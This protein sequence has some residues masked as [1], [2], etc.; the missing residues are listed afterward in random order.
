MKYRCLVLD[1]DDTV[2]QTEKTIGFPYF[3]NYIEKIR[4]GMTLTFPEYVRDCN[5][6]VFADMCRQ[7]WN[8]TEAELSEE[9][10]GWKAYSRIHAPAVCDGIGEV[11]LRQKEAGGLVCVS[12][13]STREIIERDFLHHFGFLPDAIYDNDLPAHQRKPNTYALERIMEDF[14]LEPEDILMV[15]DMKLGWAMASAIGADTA[16]AG[17]SKQEFPELSAQMRALCRYSFDSPRDL[18][19][20]LFEL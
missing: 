11:I 15:D 1:H 5:N 9:Y 6:T 8:M 17:W 3:R 18:E 19:K 12:S 7:R 13:L 4:P 2:V 16:F 10:L 14:S 20:F